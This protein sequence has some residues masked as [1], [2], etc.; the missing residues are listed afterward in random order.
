MTRADA[1]LRATAFFTARDGGVSAPPFD[2]LNLSHGVGD[3]AAHV[4]ANRER[5]AV[6]A[7]APVAYMSQIH[8][9]LAALVSGSDEAPEADA[10]ITATPGLALAV[11]VADCVPILAHHPD[12]GAVAAIHAGRRGV[13]S[14]VVDAAI[15]RLREIAGPGAIN[16]SI[17]PAICGGC[18]EVP[19][20]LR[21]EVARS[22]PEARAE[23]TW[24]TPSLDLVAAVR[25]Q[26][27]HAG[28]HVVRVDSR[29]TRESPDLFSHRRDGATGRFAGVIVCGPATG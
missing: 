16:A 12:S 17:G 21:D 24:G 8:G 28:V 18:Y 19:A 26:L 22:V 7:G 27:R 14:G 13:H 9:A 6:L 23:T 20:E 10:L 29:C 3:D 25:A 15:G 5:L 1:G 11:M 2:S 4:A